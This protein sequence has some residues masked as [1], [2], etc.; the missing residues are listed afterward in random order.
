MTRTGVV[1]RVKPCC[2][3]GKARNG[4]PNLTVLLC[5]LFPAKQGQFLPNKEAPVTS[6]SEK[7]QWKGYGGWQAM[8]PGRDIGLESRK[9]LE[10]KLNLTFWVYLWTPHFHTVSQECR[11]GVPSQEPLGTCPNCHNSVSGSTHISELG[12]HRAAAGDQGW[13]CHLQGTRGVRKGDLAAK[14]GQNRGKFEAP[15]TASPDPFPTEGLS[16]WL[17]DATPHHHP[18]PAV[19]II[20]I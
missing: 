11:A 8:A 18:T 2:I 1:S 6:R 9:V 16:S 7:T 10:E 4:A 5:Q 19:D 3:P 12:E 13:N 17:R 14:L 20:L 15:W